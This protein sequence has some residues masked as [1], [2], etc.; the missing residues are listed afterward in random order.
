MHGIVTRSDLLRAEISDREIEGRV[1]KGLLIRLHP[2]VYSVGPRATPEARYLAAVRACGEGAVL[3]AMPAGWLFGIVKGRPPL[4]EVMTRTERR[5]NGVRTRRCRRMDRRDTT[6][7]RGIPVTTVP[8][9]LVDLAATL[10]LTDLARACHEAGVRYRTTP[11]KVK[12]VLERHPKAPGKANLTRVID[13]DERVLL[14]ALERSFIEQ[15]RMN[16]L[17]LPI[18]N[19]PAGSKYVDCRWPDH[20]LTVELDSY[21]FHNSRHSW[22]QGYRREREA[23]ARK[24]R[25]RRFTWADVFEDPAYM[26]SELRMLLA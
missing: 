20:A 9:T 12:A 18:A 14:S 25:F 21:A 13:G 11:R 4:P 19:R 3:V 5:V 22:E 2:G 1:R 7:H 6:T 16:G 23:R 17:P 15:L 10:S 26:L 24:E 8:R